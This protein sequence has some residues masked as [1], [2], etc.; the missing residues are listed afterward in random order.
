MNEELLDRWIE[1]LRRA[2][3]ELRKEYN[4]SKKEVDYEKI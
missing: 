1:A 3:E 2:E 4:I